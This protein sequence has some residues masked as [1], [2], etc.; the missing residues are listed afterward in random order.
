MAPPPPVE[1]KVRDY[2][3]YYDTPD[4]CDVMKKAMVT[5]RYG[6]L[7]GMVL[8][9]YDILMYS[10]ASGLIPVLKRY[11]LH[12]VPLGLIGA[13]FALVANGV[14][15]AR[16]KDDKLNYFLGGF[17]CGPICAAYLGS[18]HMALIGG[19][20]LGVAGLLK[21]DAIDQGFT[22]VPDM[23]GHKGTVWKWRMDFTLAEDPRDELMHTCDNN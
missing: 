7:T 8:S 9:T 15:N 5:T 13:T 2:Y 19:L 14:Q 6:V 12:T 17:A 18:K 16:E 20:A 1:K 22:L 3:R 11:A 21:K 10:H 4:G 23:H